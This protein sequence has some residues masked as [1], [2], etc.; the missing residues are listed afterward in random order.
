MSPSHKYNDYGLDDDEAYDEDYVPPKRRLIPFRLPRQSGLLGF[1]L[2]AGSIVG[3]IIAAL[4]SLLNAEPYGFQAMETGIRTGITI[5]VLFWLYL[6]IIEPAGFGKVLKRRS[7]GASAAIRGL[8]FFGLIV[9]GLTVNHLIYV[10]LYDA[11]GFPAYFLDG[12]L[13][14]DACLSLVFSLAVFFIIDVSAMVGPRVLTNI[15]LGRYHHPVR[16]DRVFLFLDVRGATALA[17][18]I[19]DEQAHE[20]LTRFFYDIDPIILRWGGEVVTYLGDGVMITW[21]LEESVERSAPLEFLADVMGWVVANAPAYQDEY[22]AIPTF[23]AGLHGGE[24]VA[25]ECGSSKREIAYIGDVV[26]I[27]AR[28][29]Q[30]CKRTRYVALA[31]T[32]I[33]ERMAL[34]DGMVTD[35]LGEMRLR[36]RERQLDVVAI[37]MVRARR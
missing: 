36:G 33:V 24:V 14:R 8:I 32:E 27:A 23:R 29:E 4:V 21:P 16:E 28:L 1:L 3:L 10:W 30:A 7:F 20:F 12:G 17:E 2:I 26:N 35:R 15:V 6:A 25:G 11:A 22:G 13:M 31:S 19:G 34:P 37:R 18:R 9:A 5:S